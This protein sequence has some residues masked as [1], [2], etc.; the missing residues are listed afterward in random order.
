MMYNFS[1]I[2]KD[3]DVIEFITTPDKSIM[4]RLYEAPK[5]WNEASETC[6]DVGGYLPYFTSRTNLEELLGFV[7]TLRITQI[8]KIFI[9]L[10]SGV[11]KIAS[12]CG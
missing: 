9:G 4:L 3:V 11:R 8:L 1:F 2:Q 10:K 7:K 5:S 6:K 12:Q